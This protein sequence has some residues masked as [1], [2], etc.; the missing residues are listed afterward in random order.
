M[1][2]FHKHKNAVDVSSPNTT[3]NSPTL[4]ETTDNNA[5]IADIH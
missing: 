3:H 5:Q 4:F 2:N 1:L